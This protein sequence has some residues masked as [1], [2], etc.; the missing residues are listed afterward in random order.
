M[1]KIHQTKVYANRFVTGLLIG[2]ASFMVH[3]EALPAE[4]EPLQLP[5]LSLVWSDEFEGDAIDPSKW[6]HEVNCY[7]GGND[8]QQCYTDRLKNAYVK[9]GKLHLVAIKESYSGARHNPESPQYQDDDIRTLPFT[10]A[11]LRTLG[12]GDWQYG[13]FEIRA[14]LPFGQGSWPAI[15][16][17]PTDWVYGGWAAS[18]EI[19]IM[20]AVNLKTLSD[21]DKADKGQRENRV[22]GTLHY[23]AAW[24]DNVYT[25]AAYQLPDNQNPADD[26]HT[27]AIEWQAGEIRWY[28]DGVHFQ[29]QTS[30]TWYSQV[31][32]PQGNQVKA[33]GHAP[34][35]QKFHLILNLAVG[36]NWAGK[37]NDTGVD[38]GIFPQTMQV[39]YVRVYQFIN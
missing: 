30:D 27:Y 38:E 13:R 25:G 5:G 32:D 17:L 15:W 7:G 21:D 29:T 31:T 39:D 14:K 23:G 4:R 16:M 12:K 2:A 24:P 26:F 9:D 33:K 37:A 8:E 22:H 20:E 35:D 19:D 11:R 6:S 36:G 3:T 28:V 10:S 1:S 18:G 34:F